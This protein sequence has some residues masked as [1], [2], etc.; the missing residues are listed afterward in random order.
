MEKGE[1]IPEMATGETREE[2]EDIIICAVALILSVLTI[3]SRMPV[4]TL[5]HRSSLVAS[6]PRTSLIQAQAITRI[7]AVQGCAIINTIN[8]SRNNNRKLVK[9]KRVTPY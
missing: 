3:S 2:T 9:L 6:V 4:L 5:L 8:A 7:P 1:P